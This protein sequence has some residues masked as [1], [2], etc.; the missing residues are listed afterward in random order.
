LL[1]NTQQFT[2]TVTGSSNTAVSWSVNGVAGGNSKVGTISTAGLYTA[3][4]DLPSPAT[5]TVT[6]TAQADTTRS[7]SASVTI[8]SDISV[9]VQSSPAGNSVVVN[10]TLNLTATVSSAGNPDKAVQWSVN[11]VANGNATLGMIAT[12]GTGTATYSAPATAPSP[13]SVTI[14]AT[15][16]ADPSKSGTLALTV[17]A[18]IAIGTL[19][20]AT[21]TPLTVL[22]IGT[23][24]VNA[25][26]PVTLQFSNSAGFSVSEQ[27]I[28]VQSDGTV[29][30]GVPLYVD[31]STGQIGPGTVSLVLTQGTLSSDP[32][33]L[34]IQD[35]PALSTYGTQLGQI[36]HAFLVFETLLHAKRLNQLQAAQQLLGTS[37]D[38]STAQATAQTLIQGSVLARGDVDNVMLNSSAVL[39]WGT[40]PDGTLLQFD[41]TQLDVMDRV[42]A[43]YLAQQ[44]GSFSRPASPGVMRAPLLTREPSGPRG[45]MT[46]SEVAACL[47]SDHTCA[48]QA[49]ENVD[50]SPN[51]TDTGLGFWSGIGSVLL[52]PVSERLS[53]GVGMVGGFIHVQ[54]ALDSMF[55]GIG[56]AANCNASTTCGSAQAQAIDNAVTSSGVSFAIADFSL[57]SHA[58]SFANSYL[59]A[60]VA[61]LAAG[62]APSQSAE[63]ASLFASLGSSGALQNALNVAQSIASKPDYTTVSANL[64]IVT[65]LAQISNTAGTAAAQTGLN[66]CCFGTAQ[67]GITGVADPAGNYD[68][69]VPIGVPMTNYSNMTVSAVDP[70][71]GTTLG[72]N[73]VNLSGISP[74]ATV[75]LSTVSGTC[76]DPDR[77]S[78]DLDDPDCD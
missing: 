5:V 27:A 44:F 62:A 31:P 14:Q 76:I 28:R 32:A 29:I 38:T 73:V 57:I 70:I 35:L 52:G 37:I 8:I 33:T 61:E 42:I 1:G 23:S 55:Q 51:P 11:G 18:R 13:A 72:S 49:A 16:V 77:F 58:S 4:Q 53:S 69:L 10:T 36:S 54:E 64:G 12:T 66:L 40:L 63:A 21:P 48:E 56:L 67:L 78:G 43:V 68:L 6:A 39:S 45:M 71:T 74:N 47:G 2:A 25:S 24:G 30:A 46:V 17:V 20:S 34:S 15:S 26:N 50:A 22:Q 60:L 59:G 65:G 7:A 19:S 75:S 3:P 9:T 41:S